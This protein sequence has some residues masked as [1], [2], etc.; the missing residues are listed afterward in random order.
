MLTGRRL[1]VRVVAR[2]SA[3]T[4]Y[5]GPRHET[6]GRATVA[7]LASARLTLDLLRGGQVVRTLTA[8]VH[9]TGRVGDG[10][11]SARFATRVPAGEPLT[12]RVTQSG[13]V[14][15]HATTRARVG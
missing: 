10:V 6:G 5:D 7:D 15:R 3:A 9:D 1:D 11:G 12:V 2:D 14:H 13:P 8:A 4:S